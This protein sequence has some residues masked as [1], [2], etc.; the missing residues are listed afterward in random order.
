MLGNLVAF[1]IPK[2]TIHT[3]L[4]QYRGA[5]AQWCLQSSNLCRETLAFNPWFL[6]NLNNTTV[7]AAN[8]FQS[9]G[10]WHSLDINLKILYFI[11]NLG[12]IFQLY[13]KG[14][15]A[16][17]LASRAK[18]TASDDTLMR[19]DKL[20]YQGKRQHCARYIRTMFLQPYSESTSCPWESFSF[21]EMSFFPRTTL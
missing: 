13:G 11:R 3:M 9:R 7:M 2:Y 6:G 1:G 15:E 16:L 12:H 18:E 8:L 17:I 21:K 5:H 4:R 20:Y 19:S 14:L 10:I